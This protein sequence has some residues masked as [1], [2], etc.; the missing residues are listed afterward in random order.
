MSV[1]LLQYEASGQ[2]ANPHRPASYIDRAYGMLRCADGDVL[3]TVQNEQEWVRLCAEVVGD[4]ALSNDARFRN[5]T[6]RVAHRAA[7]EQ[8]M[9]VR[10]TA[11]SRQALLDSLAA[12][13][14]VSTGVQF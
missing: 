1:P 6:A 2:P 3:L 13:D 12:A 4:A 10:F 9:R 8:L 11:I 14:I 5:N 7:L